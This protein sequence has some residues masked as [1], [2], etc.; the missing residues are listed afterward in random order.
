MITAK[1]PKQTAKS[2]LEDPSV[3]RRLAHVENNSKAEAER[4]WQ[5]ICKENK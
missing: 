3:K 1:A 5:W 4:E 2:I